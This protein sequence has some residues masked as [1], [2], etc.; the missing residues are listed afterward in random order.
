MHNADA[1]GSTI[2]LA[3]AWR[4]VAAIRAGSTRRSSIMSLVGLAA[5]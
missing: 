5:K 4:F 2:R 3:P 1:S